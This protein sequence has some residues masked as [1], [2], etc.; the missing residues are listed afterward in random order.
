MNRLMICCIA[1]TTL[2][3]GAVARA[4]AKPIDADDTFEGRTYGEW[5]GAWWTWAY[6]MP[7]SKNPLNQDATISAGVDCNFFQDPASKVFFLAGTSIG[8]GTNVQRT[9]IVPADKHLF[10]PLI[11]FAYDN[12]GT[13][14]TFA[15]TNDQMKDSLRDSLKSV[16]TSAL[17][18]TLDGKDIPH[19]SKY[20][21]KPGRSFS[22]VVP[23]TDSIYES[24]YGVNFWGVVNPSFTSG[25]YLLLTPLT[26]GN[27]TLTFGGQ[28]TPCQSGMSTAGCFAIKVSYNLV[29]LESAH[30]QA[31]EK[32]E[33]D[34]DQDD[35][36]PTVPAAIQIPS[37]DSVSVLFSVFASG[38]QNYTCSGGAW[39]SAVPEATLY[40][41][42][43]A[44]APMIGQHFAG[45]EWFFTDSSYVIGDK[46]NIIK[47]AAPNPTT[48]IPW[49]L[50]PVASTSA[51]GLLANVVFVQRVNTSG[52]V[53]SNT[54]DAS[55]DGAV[56][57]VPYTANYF[58]FINN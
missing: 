20:A 24:L 43:D 1:M 26:P 57:K 16:D 18:A 22:Y 35:T 7:Y 39:S 45:P 49:L 44:T 29:V 46:P 23:Y 41:G 13:P 9:C 51:T 50:V 25:Y 3:L 28:T 38:T 52:G 42:A 19:L 12:G 15:A 54:C 53:E 27:H 30:D 37:T 6:S 31:K 2:G 4:D 21:V 5:G 48:D 10:F 56:D 58:F 17:V 40:A 32:K 8:D 34:S 47:A 14:N 11:N 55:N 36:A 33:G